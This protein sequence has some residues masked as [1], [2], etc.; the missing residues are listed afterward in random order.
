MHMEMHRVAVC[1]VYKTQIATMIFLP[2]FWQKWV[3]EWK[4]AVAFFFPHTDGSSAPKQKHLV[5][6]RVTPCV[7][8]R[9]FLKHEHKRFFFFSWPV[10]SSESSS[11]TGHWPVHISCQ[12]ESPTNQQLLVYKSPTQPDPNILMCLLSVSFSLSQDLNWK[13][14]SSLWVSPS[15]LA[16]ISES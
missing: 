6:F 5:L 16:D 8:M 14:L 3:N 1:L 2:F 9:V 13:Y 7:F 10:V 4:V 12:H 11:V 15:T